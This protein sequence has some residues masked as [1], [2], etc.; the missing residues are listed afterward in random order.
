[1]RI[2]TLLKFNSDTQLNTFTLVNKVYICSQFK[3]FIDTL[4]QPEKDSI[5]KIITSFKE[6]AQNGY[7]CEKENLNE[8]NDNISYNGITLGKTSLFSNPLTAINYPIFHA[9]IAI[10]NKP[11]T[12]RITSNLSIIYGHYIVNKEAIIIIFSI[13]SS[14]QPNM[15]KQKVQSFIELY[16]KYEDILNAKIAKNKG[17]I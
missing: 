2:L 12:G 6:A 11:K 9:H 13:E 7:I 10:F 14:H 8:S 16:T 15:T 5:Q 4:N 1:M 3:N 17:L